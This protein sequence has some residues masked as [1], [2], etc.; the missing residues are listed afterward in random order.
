[1][2]DINEIRARLQRAAAQKDNQGS[3]RGPS[4]LYRHWDAPDDSRIEVRFLPD[5]NADNVY[6]W[7][8]KQMIKLEF[9]SVLGQPDFNKG[10][11]F[12]VQVPCVEMYNDG[13]SCPVS[14]EVSSWFNTDMDSLARKYWKK[15]SYIMQGFVLQDPTNEEQ[16]P[17]NPIR[18][19][20]INSQIFKNV[21]EGLL[22][23]D[24]L[25]TP[26]DYNNGTNFVIK[27]TKNGQYADYTTSNWSR[28][29]S[30]LSQEHMDAIQK[31]ELKDLNTLLPKV[32]SDEDLLIIKDMF[33][34]SVSGEPYDP[35]R[36]GEHFRPYGLKTE[37]NNSEQ[38]AKQAPSKPA[39]PA[40]AAKA[41]DAPPFSPSTAEPRQESRPAPAASAT[42]APAAPAAPTSSDSNVNDIL[43]KI[44]SRQN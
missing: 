22:D 36:W 3:S 17:E 16:P 23:P 29:E 25:H 14:R 42:P 2:P 12:I 1:M 11:P 21:R 33:E 5:A 9:S 28:N 18:Q 30:A 13:R 24:M 7:R 19:F 8:E 40:Q 44:R 39:D 27:K 35:S 43:A 37:S 32:P 15:R 6:F 34:A 20:N 41:D 26:T 31:Y 10:K 38:G 4:P